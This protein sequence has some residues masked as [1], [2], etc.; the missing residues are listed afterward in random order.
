MPTLPNPLASNVSVTRP[1]DFFKSR[2]LHTRPFVNNATLDTDGVT[3]NDTL[4][5][6]V[7]NVNTTLY[8]SNGIKFVF[9]AAATMIG[10]E[11]NFLVTTAGTGGQMRCSFS[12]TPVVSDLISAYTVVDD[13]DSTSLVLYNPSKGST[14]KAWCDGT[15]WFL[16][17]SMG[18]VSSVQAI[19]CAG[20]SSTTYSNRHHGGTSIVDG[21]GLSTTNG[22]HTLDFSGVTSGFKHNV[23]IKEVSATGSATN[24]IKFLAPT[25]IYMNRVI[26]THN[27]T[28]GATLKSA[29]NGTNL[30]MKLTDTSGTTGFGPG[31]FEVVV[32]D[33]NMFILGNYGQL[34]A[35]CTEA[36]T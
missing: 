9:P 29:Y 30:S 1:A 7:I 17:G 35:T 11:Y 23:V 3:L 8:G 18:L 27:G 32:T 36:A 28:T 2:E 20:G 33:T 15:K 13:Q 34:A 26:L 6:A 10:M 22:T 21:S 24:I 25:G 16:T 4:C 5:N 31:N 12:E 14:F 19:T